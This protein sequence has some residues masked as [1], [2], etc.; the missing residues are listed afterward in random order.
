[1]VEKLIKFIPNLFT[2]GNLFLGLLGI[3]FCFSDHIFPA[4]VSAVDPSGKNLAVIFGF[5]SRLYLASFMIYGAALLDFADGFVARALK[6]Q[7]ALGAQLDSLADV[8]TFGVLPACIYF[9]LLSA[10]HHLEPQAL[11]VPVIN[12]VP[13]FLIALASAYRLAKFN[14]DERQHD[15]FIGLATPAM[16]ILTASLPLIVFTNAFGLGEFILNR[17]LLYAFVIGLSWL[18][19]SEVPMFSLKVKSFS[20]KGNQGTLAFIA[21]CLVLVVWLKYTGIAASI[22]LYI[23]IC[24]GKYFFGIGKANESNDP[25]QNQKTET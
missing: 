2:L 1:M 7:S 18:M 20:W 13:A 10:A 23:L 19:I 9:Q 15:S 21:V 14:I 24:L 11:Y 22:L 12:M 4:E 8:V 25:H 3:V 6:A 16:G 5:N 17:W